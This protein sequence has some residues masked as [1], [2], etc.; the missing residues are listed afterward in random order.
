LWKH[1]SS[2]LCVAITATL[3]LI[4]SSIPSDLPPTSSPEL[5]LLNCAHE[6]IQVIEGYLPDL[7]PRDGAHLESWKIEIRG[8]S[9]VC[10]RLIQQPVL[11]ALANAASRLKVK[12]PTDGEIDRE[13]P[14]TTFYLMSQ[15]DT[16]Q[17]LVLRDDLQGDTYGRF[18]GP[19][20]PGWVLRRLAKKIPYFINRKTRHRTFLDP[21]FHLAVMALGPLPQGWKLCFTMQS[22]PRPFYR[23]IG[24]EQDERMWIRP[25]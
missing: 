3:N 5:P 10:P 22:E 14:R 25:R 7:S 8:L 15:E 12:L 4:V 24:S 11:T 9:R 21:R 2:A 18:T 23:H 13:H 6:L 1:A 19:L 20:P 16:E 17:I